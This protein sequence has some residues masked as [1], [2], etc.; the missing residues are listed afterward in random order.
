MEWSWEVYFVQKEE[1]TISHL[2]V[3]Y[4]FCKLVWHEVCVSV[5]ILNN[6]ESLEFEETFI[7]WIKWFSLHKKFLIFVCWYVWK[8]KK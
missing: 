8:A 6:W 7:S 2:F 1:E 5:G 4:H 3:S